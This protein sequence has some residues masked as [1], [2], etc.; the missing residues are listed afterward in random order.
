MKL[1]LDLPEEE[2]GQ[3]AIFIPYR[4]KVKDHNKATTSLARGAK[5]PSLTQRELTGLVGVSL[6]AI[7]YC[8]NALIDRG[9]LKT[10]NFAHSKNK[11]KYAY[12]LT[13]K[14]IAEKSRLTK[15]FLQR[16][17]IE[18]ER[19]PLRIPLCD[20]KKITIDKLSISA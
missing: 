8:I 14:G 11:L 13:P 15:T 12:L 6:G 17:L 18:Y 20:L 4:P 9:F 7:N 5:T 1:S 2:L 10:N 3:W 19:F 16:K